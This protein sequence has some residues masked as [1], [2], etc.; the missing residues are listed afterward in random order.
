M[1]GA[2]KPLEKNV[3]TCE[4]CFAS[5]CV[6]GDPSDM[7]CEISSVDSKGEFIYKIEGLCE[8]CRPTGKYSL[9]NMKS[10]MVEK[11]LE[12]KEYPSDE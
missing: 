9:T 4:K 6:N 2:I 5:Y 7:W 11:K 8:F 12:Q 3:R 1:M 10:D